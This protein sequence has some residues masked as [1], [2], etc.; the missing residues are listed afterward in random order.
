MLKFTAA[1]SERQYLCSSMGN[2]SVC[3][4]SVNNDAA[5]LCYISTYCNQGDKVLRMNIIM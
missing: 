5:D 2:D 4:K 1:F 3:Y